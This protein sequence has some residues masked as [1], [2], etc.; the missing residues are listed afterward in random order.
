MNERAFRL[1]RQL[2]EARAALSRERRVR[3][4]MEARAERLGRRAEALQAALF[5]LLAC[6]EASPAQ[7]AAARK[8]LRA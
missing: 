8:A 1:C 4:A 7:R 5:D 3:Q 6:D 2:A